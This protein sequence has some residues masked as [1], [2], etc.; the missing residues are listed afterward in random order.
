MVPALAA[1]TQAGDQRLVT[2]FAFGFG[3][4]QQLAALCNHHQQT[5]TRVVVFL[6]I[7][8][9][10]GQGRN[11]RSQ[12]SNLYFGRTGVTCFGGIFFDQLGFQF[13]ILLDL[14]VYTQHNLMLC[15]P[16]IV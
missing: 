8:E 14:K 16:Q 12:D 10:L 1:D 7:F 6:V 15:L 11:A 5:T 9:M 13:Y 4:V 3:V 2:L